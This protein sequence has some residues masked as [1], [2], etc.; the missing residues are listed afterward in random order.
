VAG[1]DGILI[2]QAWAAPVLRG[3]HIVV[4]GRILEES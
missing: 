2:A 3:Q 1:V 4:V